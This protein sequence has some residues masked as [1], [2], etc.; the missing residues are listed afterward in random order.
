MFLEAEE[1]GDFGG[2]LREG[3]GEFAIV[4]LLVG[5]HEEIEVEGE[6]FGGGVKDDADGGAGDLVF[7]ADVGDDLGFH[8][9]GVGAG[10]FPELAFFGGG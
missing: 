4:H 10:G 2:R 5:G 3:E 6:V 7:A 8:F 1:G 9:D